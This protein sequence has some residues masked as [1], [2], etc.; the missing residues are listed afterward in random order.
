MENSPA[1]NKKKGEKLEEVL[2]GSIFVETRTRLNS[3]SSSPISIR[4]LNPI[5]ALILLF[6]VALFGCFVVLPVVIIIPVNYSFFFVIFLLLFLRNSLTWFAGCSPFRCNWGSVLWQIQPPKR[7]RKRRRRKR[8]EA[9]SDGDL[10]P[11]PPPSFSVWLPSFQ[12]ILSSPLVR[13][14]NEKTDPNLATLYRFLVLEN[15]TDLHTLGTA[16]QIAPVESASLLT[17]SWL[18]YITFLA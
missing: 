5:L 18:D 10:S 17:P 12:L 3:D 9:N 8:R 14:T 15:E 4:V 11:P 7:P 1:R 2:F 16:N 6:P 13:K